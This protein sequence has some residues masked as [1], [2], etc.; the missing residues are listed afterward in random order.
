MVYRSSRLR[1]Y[2]HEYDG[3]ELQGEDN[4]S[5]HDLVDLA[6]QERHHSFGT[7]VDL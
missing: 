6:L 7:L 4:D 5:G 1:A 2:K 3:C